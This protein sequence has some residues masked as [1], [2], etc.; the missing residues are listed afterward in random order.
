MTISHN[1]AKGAFTVPPLILL[2]EIKFL[3]LHPILQC[4]DAAPEPVSVFLSEYIRVLV[5]IL[6]T[7]VSV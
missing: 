5:V 3:C 6:H 1:P 7:V 4:S 2:V